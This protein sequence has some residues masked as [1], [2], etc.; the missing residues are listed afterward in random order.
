MT[1]PIEGGLIQNN[2]VAIMG[3]V[4]AIIGAVLII[5]GIV[6]AAFLKKKSKE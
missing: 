5:A 1:V 6:L 3:T 4:I 2:P